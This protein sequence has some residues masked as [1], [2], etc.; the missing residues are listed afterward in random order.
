MTT[1]LTYIYGRDKYILMDVS[2]MTIKFSIENAEDLTRVA[3]YFAGGDLPD[4][5]KMC[6]EEGLTN[7]LSLCDQSDAMDREERENGHRDQ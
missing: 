4:A 5:L 3:E 6:M 7:I 2:A 1:P